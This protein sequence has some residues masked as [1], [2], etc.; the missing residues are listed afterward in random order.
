MVN[1]K[2]FFQ[3]IL[4]KEK[5]W[6]IAIKSRKNNKY[7]IFE[8]INDRYWYA[9]PMLFKYENINYL[10]FERFDRES[11]KGSICYCEI[12]N[13]CIDVIS[14]AIEENFHMSYPTLFVYKNEI[15]M[16]PE[17]CED[18]SII[19]YKSLKFPSKWC[20]CYRK[21]TPEKYVDHNIIIYKDDLYLVTSELKPDDLLKTRLKVF[22]L[23]FEGSEINLIP[24]VTVGTLGDYSYETRGGGATIYDNEKIIRPVQISRRNE[25]G[26]SLSF[27]LVEVSFGKY[28]EIKSTDLNIIYLNSDNFD[29]LGVHTYCCNKDYEVIDIKVNI[30]LTYKQKIYKLV[31]NIKRLQRYY[32][33]TGIKQTVKKLLEKLKE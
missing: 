9:D 11:Q 5:C 14:P 30:E 21:S 8:D 1:Y 26:A 16:I 3:V 31:R 6:T 25:Y 2:K 33:R 23:E 18:D 7:N 29:L 32:R 24:I 17:T 13:G 19:I 20:R 4:G 12:K 10:F 27:N 28:S 22:K 15:Y